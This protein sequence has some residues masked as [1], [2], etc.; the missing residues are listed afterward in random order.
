MAGIPGTLG[1]AL[2]MNAGIRTAEGDMS[3]GGLVQEVKAVDMKG[4]EKILSKD[5]LVFGYRRSNLKGLIL[6][7]ASMI[8]TEADKD[9]VISNTNDYLE[10]RKRK[11][12]YSFPGAGCIFKNPEDGIETAGQLI[13]RLGFKGYEKGGVAVSSKHANFILNRSSATAEDMLKVIKTIRS[14]AKSSY[15]VDLDL[16]IEIV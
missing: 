8:L 9:T 6:I 3:I 1:G 4:N 2:V 12:D 13:D 16:E 15:G 14:R 11:C 5:E 10:R 7:E